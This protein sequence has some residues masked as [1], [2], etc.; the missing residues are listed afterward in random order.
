MIYERIEITEEDERDLAQHVSPKLRNQ[1]LHDYEFA[2]RCARDGIL[3]YSKECEE[4]KKIIKR[5]DEII[6][7]LESDIEKEEKNLKNIASGFKE[8][9]YKMIDKMKSEK[10]LLQRIKD[11]WK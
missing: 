6:K 2:K 5:L 3:T 11:G 7:E 1:L 8:M 10:K 4:Q 9:T